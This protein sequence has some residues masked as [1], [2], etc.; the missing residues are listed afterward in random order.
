MTRSAAPWN[1]ARRSVPRCR[2]S[3]GDCATRGI[4][5]IAIISGDHEAPTRKLA[6]ELG[7]DRY[8]AQVLPTEKADYVEKLQKEGR[9]VCFVG[10]GINDAIA[11]KKANVS[12]SLRGATSIATDTAHVVFMEPGLGK[13]CELRDIAT[14]LERN[15]RIS[16][17]L[18]LAPNILCI[19][20]VFTLGF[21]IAASVLTNNVA[22]L[23]ALP[24]GVRPMRKV[25]AYEAERRH[26]L[27]L[28]L[29]QSGFFDAAQENVDGDSFRKHDAPEIASTTNSDAEAPGNGATVSQQAAPAPRPMA[30]ATDPR[31]HIFVIDSGWNC[32]A[33]KVVADHI[34]ILTH[35]NID[36]ELYVLDRA[37]SLAL[38]RHY[39]LQVGRDPTIA[40]HDLKPRH[41]H[42]VRHTHGFRMHLGILDDEHQ[43][44]GALKMFARSS[45]R[46]VTR[47]I[48]TNWSARTCTGKVSLAPFRS[49]AVTSITN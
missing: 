5:H 10:D 21:G 44:L 24:N 27:E 1:C 16:W 47:T 34:D 13:L 2:T 8:F 36:D 42:R 7:I 14:E 3:S 26:M 4:Q 22:A 49:L 29:H 33:S 30:A 28:Q 32:A 11:L 38:L 46:T 41:R 48:S 12:I 43:V 19:V 23:G 15:V 31:F 20:G 45:S 40:V 35:L 18:I 17:G 37:T 9:K 39:P 6:K 25:A